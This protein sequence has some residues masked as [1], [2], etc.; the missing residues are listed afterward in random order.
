[1]KKKTYREIYIDYH[2]KI[3]KDYEIHHKIPIRMGG[4]DDIENL[5]ALPRY[6]HALR[7]KKLYEEYGDVRDLCAY[8]MLSGKFDRKSQSSIAGKIGGQKTYEEKLGIHNYTPEIKSEWC[9]K[10]G[11]IGG[12]VQ[13]KKKIGIH[14]IKEKDPKKYKEWRSKGGKNGPLRK[15]YYIKQGFSKEEAE[16]KIKEYQ[17][18]MG[19]RGGIK[20]KGSIWINDGNTSKKYTA[21]EQ[22]ELSI[23]D[24][25]NQN[26][27]YRLG[28]IQR[29][30]TK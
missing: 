21:S 14:G 29:R 23:E 11:K 2:G 22:K 17:S 1:M 15:E 30:N 13:V 6:K 24:F 12:M 18:E 5:E 26:Q 9:R 7:H 27:Q 16:K 20:N 3:P 19:K 4:T 8:Y 25:L 28:R 10:A